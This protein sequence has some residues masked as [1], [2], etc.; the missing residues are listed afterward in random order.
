L[1]VNDRIHHFTLCLKFYRQDSKSC[2]L[3]K[4]L[5]NI[6]I[7]FALWSAY[8]S[9]NILN[10]E[11]MMERRECFFSI[12]INIFITR[13]LL[14]SSIVCGVERND[15][16]RFL[17]QTSLYASAHICSILASFFLLFLSQSVC[18]ILNRE[19]ISYRTRQ[20]K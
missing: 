17:N 6:F 10:K 20:K 7:A 8:V 14:K 2:S 9:V 18:Y 11:S 3:L 16:A 13:S 5:E 19:W 12:L 1:I 4:L 15:I